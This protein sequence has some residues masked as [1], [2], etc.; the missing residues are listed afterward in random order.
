MEIINYVGSHSAQEKDKLHLSK[1]RK[2]KIIFPFSNSSINKLSSSG[3]V[4]L[5]VDYRS[6][7]QKYFFQSN[8]LNFWKQSF[9]ILPF[10]ILL[11]LIPFVI[12][13]ICDISENYPGPFHLKSLSDKELVE[14]NTA[15]SKFAMQKEKTEYDENGNILNSDGSIIHPD[16]I[17][18]YNK[19][20]FKTYTVKEGDTISEI[21]RKE[22]LTNISTLIGVNDIDNVRELRAGQKLKIPSMDGLNYIVKAGDTLAGISLRYNVAMEDLLDINDLSSQTITVG[23]ELFIPGA[24]LNSSTLRNAMGDLFAY[25]LKRKFRISSPF[26]WRADPFTNQRSFHTG[27]DMA[28]PKGTPIYASMSGKIAFVGW[29]NIFGNYVIINHE[30]GYQTLYAH[31]SKT[32]AHKGQWVSQGTRIGLVGTTGYSTGPH[33]HFTVYKNGKLI[34]PLTVLNK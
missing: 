33:L 10:I 15:M 27:I 24:K 6:S 8:F 13:G 29:S 22:G 11:F 7:Y 2:R 32:L 12:L 5:A 4:N 28:V 26:G 31:M 14:L 30:N 3:I 25:P 16:L 20:S 19:I 18:I 17:K 21:T 1:I 34:N 23:Q 9:K